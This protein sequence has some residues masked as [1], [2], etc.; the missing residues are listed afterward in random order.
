[1]DESR[2]EVIVASTLWLISG[3]I[4]DPSPC[5]CRVNAI[6]AHLERMMRM[7][8]VDPVL[9]ATAILLHENWCRVARQFDADAEAA[10][11]LADP[12]RRIVH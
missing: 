11:A 5:A 9:R 8:V 10:V 12:A 7:E 1:M 2:P 6:V 3:C 4:F